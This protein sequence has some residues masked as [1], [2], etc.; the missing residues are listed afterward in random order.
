MVQNLLK[1]DL[2]LDAHSTQ[3]THPPRCQDV[4]FLYICLK[5]DNY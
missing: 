5:M 3:F 4:I 1:Y 2:R